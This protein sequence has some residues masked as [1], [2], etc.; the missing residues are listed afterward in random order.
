MNSQKKAIIIARA[1]FE[2]GENEIN[3][4]NT[5]LQNYT[6]E[7]EFYVIKSFSGLENGLLHESN[8]FNQALDFID[9]QTDKITIVSYNDFVGGE[10]DISE[11]YRRLIRE[12]KVELE[13]YAHPCFAEPE[14]NEIKIWR[15]LTLPKFI[16]LLHSRTL[17]F[18]RADLLRGEDKAEGSSL[19]NA[20][21]D[22]IKFFDELSKR[23]ISIPHQN[24]AN[25]SINDLMALSQR[26]HEVSE[27]LLIKR[28]FINCWHMN[29]HESFAMWKIYSEPFGV[30]IQSTYNSLT[31]S[32]NDPEYNFHKHPKIYSGEVKYINWDSDS[33]PRDNGFWPVMH[34]KREFKYENELR[35]IV[36]EHN[37][38]IVKVGVDLEQLIHNIHINPYTPPWFHDVIVSLCEK[39]GVGANKIIQSRL[40]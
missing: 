17:F 36:W 27:E 21:L 31:R 25:T 11:K 13:L 12:E 32:F 22:A 34:K 30:C 24:L 5:K 3:Q 8:L 38:N 40:A 20:D 6:K 14:N 23:N 37:K 28:F 19:T 18:T 35:C 33:M 29:E 15:Y 1:P 7:N 2:A 16:D 10:S 4:R 26:T 9:N 39:Y